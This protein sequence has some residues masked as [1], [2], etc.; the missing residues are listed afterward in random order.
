VRSVRWTR[1]RFSPSGPPP[2]EDGEWAGL[3]WVLSVMSWMKALALSSHGVPQRRGVSPESVGRDECGLLGRPD[4]KTPSGPPPSGDGV[5]AGLTWGLFVMSWMGAQALSL[6]GVP[7][8][9][10]ISPESVGSE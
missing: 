2:C 7:Q 8:R 10:G 9:R 1:G 3:T 4:G 5:W 6:H